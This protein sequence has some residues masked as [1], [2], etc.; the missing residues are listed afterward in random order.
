M[1]IGGWPPLDPPVSRPD[2]GGEVS[3]ITTRGFT[4]EETLGVAA[5][6]LDLVIGGVTLKGMIPAPLVLVVEDV[7]PRDAL[8]VLV[9]DTVVSPMF[10]LTSLG[11]YKVRSKPL[12]SAGEDEWSRSICDRSVLPQSVF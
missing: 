9:S 11:S 5:A 8:I 10:T 4:L 1:V 7:V 2:G 12:K 3:L 6:A